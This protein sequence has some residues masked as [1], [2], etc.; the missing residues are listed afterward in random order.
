MINISKYIILLS[1]F[2]PAHGYS[3]NINF[4]EDAPVA[5]FNEEDVDLMLN[6]FY[7]AMDNNQDG[8][9]SEWKNEK[10]GHHGIATPLNTIEGADGVC[11]NVKIENFASSEKGTSEFRFCKASDGEWQIV[12]RKPE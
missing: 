5:Q 10:T 12:E 7:K 6:N 3:F 4:L 1:L 11:R 9:S 8:E 2:F